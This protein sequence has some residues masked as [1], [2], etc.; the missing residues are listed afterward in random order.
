M[1]TYAEL[2]LRSLTTIT[3]AFRSAPSPVLEA[4]VGEHEGKTIGP[5]WLTSLGPATLWLT[6][7]GGWCGKAF[8]PLPEGGDQIVGTNLVRRRGTIR[9]SIPITAR[10]ASSRVDGRPAIRVDYPATARFP[11]R[12]VTDELRPL[13]EGVLLGLTWGIPGGPASGTP[14]VLRQRA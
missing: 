4:L 7:M 3:E 2:D 9:P 13:E 12:R 14:F 1:T 8:Q 5:V 11:W 10:I 6:G